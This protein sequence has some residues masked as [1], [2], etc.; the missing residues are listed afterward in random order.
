MDSRRSSESQCAW[1]PWD[2][3][4]PETA[5]CQQGARPVPQVLAGVCDAA[6]Q[7][8]RRTRGTQD[9]IR[10]L[11]D[12]AEEE[13]RVTLVL[14][15]ELHDS[16]VAHARSE[17]PLEACGVLTAPMGA[18]RPHTFIPMV[19]ASQSDRFYEFDTDELLSLH[20]HM[21]ARGEDIIAIYHSHTATEAIP[22]GV[23]MRM[24]QSGIHYIITSTLDGSVRSFVKG[25]DG[26]MTE[27]EVRVT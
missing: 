4:S 20:R 3:P 15:R 16:I 18:N 24:A 1:C 10:D 6:W 5:A 11:S 17:A 2:C 19:N 7:G 22:S 25:E 27:E 21:E 12:Y 26:S 9:V 14:T 8:T 23:D 13:D